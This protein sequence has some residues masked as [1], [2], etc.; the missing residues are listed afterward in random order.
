M[1]IRGILKN[2]LKDKNGSVYKIFDYWEFWGYVLKII[3]CLK[4]EVLK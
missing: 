3:L 4:L 1:V 2:L